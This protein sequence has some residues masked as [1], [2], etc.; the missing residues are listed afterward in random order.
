M[1]TMTNFRTILL[2]MDF[3]ELEPSIGDK[4]TFKYMIGSVAQGRA[5]TVHIGE[6]KNAKLWTY[7]V[8]VHKWGF[9]THFLLNGTEIQDE[10]DD[11]YEKQ[12]YG[13]ESTLKY[14]TAELY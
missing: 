11:M 5:C 14:I 12:C 4:Y 9:K 8:V 2:A 13:A 10:Y 3:E 7:S 1:M 6:T